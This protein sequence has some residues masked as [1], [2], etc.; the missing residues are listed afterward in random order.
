M[1]Y[2]LSFKVSLNWWKLYGTRATCKVPSKRNFPK[3]CFQKKWEKNCFALH[4][5]DIILIFECFWIRKV[6]HI[7]D[8][9]V[10]IS[11]TQNGTCLGHHLGHVWDNVCGIL[12]TM[13][14]NLWHPSVMPFFSSAFSFEFQ[15]TFEGKK[16]SLQLSF[17]QMDSLIHPRWWGGYYQTVGK[18]P[19]ITPSITHN[20]SIS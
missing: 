12:S 18:L 17:S 13:D 7:L 11:N 9:W 10:K 5:M 3:Y 1:I 19:P 15:K 14:N 2:W 6:I 20:P 4:H 16:E 8:S